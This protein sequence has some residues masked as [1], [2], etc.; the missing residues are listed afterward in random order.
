MQNKTKS[1]IKGLSSAQ[2]PAVDLH[3]MQHKN[4]LPKKSKTPFAISAM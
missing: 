2:N 4:Q 1:L 3:F